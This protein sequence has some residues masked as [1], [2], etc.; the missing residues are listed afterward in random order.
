MTPKGKTIGR[1]ELIIGE[2]YTSNE[3]K[4]VSPGCSIQSGGDYAAHFN[5]NPHGKND[6][7]YSPICANHHAPLAASEYHMHVRG[8]DTCPEGFRNAKE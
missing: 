4:H 6:G 8:W 7:S 1:K 3:M 5:K 2:L